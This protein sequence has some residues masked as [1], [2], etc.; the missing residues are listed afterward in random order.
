MHFDL[1][2][3][4]TLGGYWLWDFIIDTD[5]SINNWSVSDVPYHRLP[6]DCC[7]ST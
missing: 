5:N 1:L 7:I 6:K 2:H 3:G 4:I